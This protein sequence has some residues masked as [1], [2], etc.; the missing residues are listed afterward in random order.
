MSSSGMG[1]QH[2]APPFHVDIG[3]QRRGVVPSM[4]LRR[5]AG[6]REGQDAKSTE[7]PQLLETL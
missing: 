2:L 1:P 7:E 3:V 5:A 6:D 4:S